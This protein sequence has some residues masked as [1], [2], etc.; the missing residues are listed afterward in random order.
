MDLLLCGNINNAMLRLGNTD[1]N[2]GV[3]LENDGKG[4]FTYVDQQHSGL[5]LKGD[6]RS[7]VMLSDRIIFGINQQPLI[8][9][10]F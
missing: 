1:A 4:N 3:L 8:T 7:A 9:Y 2:Y 10:K 5:K 6:V